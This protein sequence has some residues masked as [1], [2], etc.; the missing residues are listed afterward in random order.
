MKKFIAKIILFFTI[1][2][3]CDFVFGK[4]MDYVVNHID[5]G[6]QGR[7]NH[8]CNS[9]DEDILIF[10]SSRAIQHYN[11][12]MMEDSLGMTCYNCGDEGNGIILSYGRLSMVREKHQPKIIIQ[13]IEPRYDLFKNDNSTYIGWL[14]ARYDREGIPEIF[15]AVDKSE[16]YK[17]KSQLYRYNTKCI[18]NIFVY[19][20]GISTDTGIKGFRPMDVEMDTTR[21]APLSEDYEFDSLKL[22]FVQKFINKAKGSK[23]I[24]VVSPI[25]NGM[26]TDMTAPIRKMC[27]EQHILFLDFSNDPKYVR[28]NDYYRDGRH[29]NA[30]G[31]DVFTRD[32]ILKL[33]EIE[34]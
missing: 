3:I 23:L 20:T 32:L 27:E 8:I 10:G 30:R 29:L 26:N 9:A 2:G 15:E 11:A 4:G 31:A 22:E 13:D 28:H 6:G 17:M 34:Q 14:K 7:D 25:W 12:Q 19:L 1:I 33:R 5:T 24:F 16:G 18:Q 21:V